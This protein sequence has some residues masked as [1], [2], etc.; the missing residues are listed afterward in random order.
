MSAITAALSQID[1][2]A[3][4]GD[5]VPEP[6]A[7]LELA[8][9]G[10]PILLPDGKRIYPPCLHGAAGRRARSRTARH[11]RPGEVDVPAAD[12]PARR[13]QKPDRP[14][15]RLP[16]LDR[17]GPPGR[18]P[19][20]GS[21]LR[22]RRAA[23]RPVLGRV[24]L[25]LRLRSGRWRRWPGG[26]RRLGVRAGDAGGVGGDDRRGQHRPRRRAALDQRHPRRA[27]QP[28]P[29]GNRR[30]RRRQAR[31]SPSCWR[32]TRVSS[33]RP[34]SPTRGTRGSRRRSRS[35][36]TG[37]RSPSSARRSR[38]SPRRCASIA[39]GSRGRTGSPGPHSSAT[40]NRCGG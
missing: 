13:R 10:E 1:G 25:P 30:D 31:G 16:P 36:A 23:T 12:R 14:R 35:R 15:N 34:T 4:E 6:A 40:S 18:R 29:G 21:V 27:A 11:A 39:S 33:A 19:A 37:R 5:L 3:A 38:W 7:A 24:L 9:P 26:A 28:V 22:V 32:T 2:V 17:P 8:T 20:R